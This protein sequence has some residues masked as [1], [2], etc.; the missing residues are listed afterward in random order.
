MHGF[1]GRIRDPADLRT[2]FE[3]VFQV[4]GSVVAVVPCRHLDAETRAVQDGGRRAA[5]SDGG[6]ARAA[7]AAQEDKIAG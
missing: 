5:R 2:F 1:A 4:P 3:S 6:G 7:V